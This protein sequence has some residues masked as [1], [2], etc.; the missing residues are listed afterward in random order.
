M[1]REIEKE[2]GEGR[3]RKEYNFDYIYNIDKKIKEQQRELEGVIEA[4][5]KILHTGSHLYKT[6]KDTA[7]AVWK[8]T[9][10]SSI[11]SSFLLPPLG[12]NNVY[13][14]LIHFLHQGLQRK[15]YS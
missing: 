9:T 12:F 7:S 15:R 14:R 4:C 2:R 10:S 8:V 11:F 13:R 5:N 6:S 1:G 3:L